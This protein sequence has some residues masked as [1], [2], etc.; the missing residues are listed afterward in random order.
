[1]REHLKRELASSYTAAVADRAL[2]YM[3]LHGVKALI[4]NKLGHKGLAEIEAEATIARE[5]PHGDEAKVPHRISTWLM[6]GDASLVSPT[7]PAVLSIR[8][9][10]DLHIASSGGIVGPQLPSGLIREILAA[11]LKGDMQ[12][13][14]STAGAADNSSPEFVIADEVRHL[15]ALAAEYWSSKSFHERVLRSGTQKIFLRNAI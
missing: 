12:L 2:I 3:R 9:A 7:D 8:R 5:A 13:V 1:M 10:I 6:S 14:C 15:F 11:L 4:R